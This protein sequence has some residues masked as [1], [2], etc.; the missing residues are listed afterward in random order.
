MIL[1]VTPFFLQAAGGDGAPA[2]QHRCAGEGLGTL[3]PIP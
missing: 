3:S 2:A 1:Q